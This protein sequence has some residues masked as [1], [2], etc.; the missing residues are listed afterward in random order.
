V[1]LYNVGMSAERERECLHASAEGW[2][3]A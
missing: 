1:V 2:W 3:T